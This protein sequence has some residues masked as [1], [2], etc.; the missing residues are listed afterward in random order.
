MGGLSCCWLG[1]LS[2]KRQQ[3]SDGGERLICVEWVEGGERVSFNKADRAGI[4]TTGQ[5]LIINKR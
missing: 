2:R 5:L 3:P 1:K 4:G